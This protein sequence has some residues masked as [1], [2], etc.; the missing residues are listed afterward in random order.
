MQIEQ[1]V[2]PE[3]IEEKLERKYRVKFR[4][5]RQVLLNNPRFRFAEK[6]HVEDEDVYAAFGQTLGGRYLSVFLFTN[7]RQKL[8]LLSVPAT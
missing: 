3:P 6:G 4:E 2:C 8:L 5:V 7:Q 1:I